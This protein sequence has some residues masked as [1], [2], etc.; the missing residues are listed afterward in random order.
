MNHENYLHK[1]QYDFG[2][3]YYY[4]GFVVGKMNAGQLVDTTIASLIIRDMQEYYKQKKFVYISNREIAHHVDL[5]VYK[6]V[7]AK[8]MIGIAIV[9]QEES[10]LSQ[11]SAEQKLY[12][13]SFG[14]FKTM[15]SAISW[16]QMLVEQPN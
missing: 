2:I 9:S 3:I 1:T 11:V 10:A 6:L 4:H 8:K 12:N 16:A 15:A 13:G 14:Y 7:D 5:S